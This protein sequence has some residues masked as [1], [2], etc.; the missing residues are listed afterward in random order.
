MIA[1]FISAAEK[2]TSKSIQTCGIVGRIYYGNH[3]LAT[4]KLIPPQLGTTDRFEETNVEDLF[5]LMS[6]YCLLSLGWIHT[7]PMYVLLSGL[8][9]KCNRY[10]Q[11]YPYQKLMLES[12]AFVYS[13]L[14]IENKLKW[15]SIKWFRIKDLYISEI[16][17]CK[18]REFHQDSVLNNEI[19]E[20]CSNLEIK[21]EFSNEE[22]YLIDLRFQ[23]Y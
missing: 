23:Q 4:H 12:V 15:T 16:E 13:G 8:L 7:H 17:K 19:F 21:N 5:N 10:T 20:E 2:N 18:E 22:N 3:L 6:K 1:K 14:P 9:L 11:H